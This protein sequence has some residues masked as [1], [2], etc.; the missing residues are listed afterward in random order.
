VAFRD[1]TAIWALPEGVDTFAGDRGV[2]LSGGEKQRISIARAMLKKADVL[3]L[4]EATSALD[5]KTEAMIQGALHVLLEK[6]TSI[7]IAHRLVTIQHA[8]HIVVLEKGKVAEQGS[9]EELLNRKGT[10]Y[11]YWERQKFYWAMI[12]CPKWSI[13]RTE[14]LSS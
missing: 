14:L 3:L 8:D 12:Q 1:S 5:T 10:F 13:C 2:R 7:V 9:L 11:N 4:D 6:K